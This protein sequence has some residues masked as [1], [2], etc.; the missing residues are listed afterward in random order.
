MTKGEVLRDLTEAAIIDSA[1]TVLAE[2]GEAATMEEIARA[3]G[4]AR[5]TLYRY[6]PNREKLLRAMTA[7]SVQELAVRIEEADLE[8]VPFEEAIARLA[9][10]MIA[11]GSKYKA[12][13]GDS[14]KYIGAYPDAHAKVIEPIRALFDRAVVAG[15]VRENFPSDVLMD[16]FSGLIT[17]ALETTASGR[18][19]IEETAAAVSSLF[20][21]GAGAS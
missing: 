9:R 12:L 18:R 4:I 1:A 21:S 11:T 5:A 2:R 6:F 20:L 13:G 10:G 19:G 15:S 17:G 3:A 8:A 16:L 14:A 7:A